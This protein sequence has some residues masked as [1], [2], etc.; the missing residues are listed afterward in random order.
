M[1]DMTPGQLKEFLES[2]AL[3][4]L[5]TMTPEGYPH[6]A[7]I[8]YEW[9]GTSLWMSTPMYTKR[10][11][12]LE[13]SLKVGFSIALPD[14][15]YRAVIGRG[16]AEVSVDVGGELIRRLCYRYLPQEKAEGFFQVV[17]ERGERTKIKLTPAWMKSWHG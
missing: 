13:K 11:K 4:D 1:N 17:M 6:V 16:D 10:I 2:K 3:I 15:P 8:W 7:P 12:N 5:A 14:L 9:D